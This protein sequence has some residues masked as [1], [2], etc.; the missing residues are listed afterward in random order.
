MFNGAFGAIQTS[1]QAQQLVQILKIVISSGARVNSLQLTVLKYRD[2]MR[3]DPPYMIKWVAGIA[4]TV[5]STFLVVNFIKNYQQSNDVELVDYDADGRAFSF[6]YPAFLGQVESIQEDTYFEVVA[7]DAD[8]NYRNFFSS[9]RGAIHFRL[10]PKEIYSVWRRSDDDSSGQSDSAYRSFID[11]IFFIDTVAFVRSS[12]RYRG[13]EKALADIDNAVVLSRRL[14]PSDDAPYEFYQETKYEELEFLKIEYFYEG[15]VAVL[16]AIGLFSV[17]VWDQNMKSI[18]ESFKTIEV[19]ES[20]ARLL[21]IK[22]QWLAFSHKIEADGRHVAVCSPSDWSPRRLEVAGCKKDKEWENMRLVGFQ[23]SDGM[24]QVW[25]IRD[26]TD[27]GRLQDLFDEGF[28][29]G[30]V[31]DEDLPAMSTDTP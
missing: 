23:C 4:A 6:K 28:D 8:L 13:S 29:A 25:L 7:G 31:N 5:I 2:V 3:N 24:E 9:R 12:S 10:W 22:D 16:W 21:F 26:R 20:A 30:E 17:P 11:P 15:K 14:S 19:D 27:C 18:R 1:D